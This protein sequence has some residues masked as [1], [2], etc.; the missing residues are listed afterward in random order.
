MTTPNRN[1]PV[2]RQPGNT[3]TL[4]W[5]A[6]FNVLGQGIDATIPLAKLTGGGVNGE[7]V[8]KSGVL[9]GFTAPT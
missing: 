2:I 9:T 4:P 3:F 1:T 8:F 6:F 7:L 5:Y